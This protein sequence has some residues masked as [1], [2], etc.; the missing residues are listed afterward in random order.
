M[1][2]NIVPKRD[3]RKQEL[4][5]VRSQDF[6]NGFTLSKFPQNDVPAG[7]P[8]RLFV[9]LAIPEE[10]R[11]NMVEYVERL[12]ARG[13]QAKWTNPD[14]WHITL[15]FIGNT[16]RDA[17]IRE[18]LQKISG[19]SMQIS[20]RGVGFFTPKRP[21]VFYA[22]IEAPQRLPELAKKIELALVPCEVKPEDKSYSPHLTLAR[23]GSGRPKGVR[24]DR[25]APNMNSL[26]QLVESNAEFQHPDFGTMTANEFILYLSELSPKGAK[27]T[28]LETYP[29]KT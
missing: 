11:G 2:R 4:Y 15:K 3:D 23:S 9:G 29:L 12:K 24:R 18:A 16:P 10:I 13:A 27:Y 21:R 14:G 5:S 26:K 17:D 28:K 6:A 7:K 25:A 19:A 22:G 1:P 20:I 8:R